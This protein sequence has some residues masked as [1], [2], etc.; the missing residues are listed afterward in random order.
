MRT[1]QIVE[2][3][4]SDPEDEAG[5]NRKASA[6]AVDDDNSVIPVLRRRKVI[7]RN[8]YWHCVVMDVIEEDVRTRRRASHRRI[9]NRR[10]GHGVDASVVATRKSDEFTSFE[11][12]E[13]PR[14]TG[15]SIDRHSNQV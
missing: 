7:E 5:C 11:E 10:K 9:H 13:V 2:K 1:L 6:N 3:D 4:A 15:K 14:A 12:I 8:Q